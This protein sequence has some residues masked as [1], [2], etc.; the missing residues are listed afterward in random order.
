MYGSP[1]PGRSLAR[2]LLVR[3]ACLFALPGIA[4]VA[5]QRQP[6]AGALSAHGGPISVIPVA[7]A[8]A[9][10]TGSLPTVRA[11]RAVP[12][13]S[14]SQPALAPIGD[15]AVRGTPTVSVAVMN[16]VLAA[17][18]SP[19]AG[20]GQA[21]YDLGVKY[22]IDPAFC[23]AFFVQ[24]SDAGTR[25][26]AVLTHSV[27]NLRPEPGAPSMDGYR[28]YYTWL[29]G[30]EDW[31]RLISNVYVDQ[32]GLRTVDAIIP[33]YAPSGDNN[34]VSTYIDNVE[35]LV[36]AWRTQNARAS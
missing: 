9:G 11:A 35:Q 15:Y 26:E 24:E 34:D 27:G 33:V 13:G 17:Y 29:E 22:G 5:L 16:Q 20:Q 1:R 28:Y 2:G 6:S 4:A 32:W 19:L 8:A 12:P 18:R 3:A 23:L 31:Y 25:G 30:A 7:T 21:L 36:A 10:R 14:A